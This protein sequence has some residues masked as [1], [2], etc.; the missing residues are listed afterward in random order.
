MTNLFASAAFALLRCLATASVAAPLVLGSAALLGT[1][2]P[3]P[4][5]FALGPH[6]AW[7]AIDAGS[8]A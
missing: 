6:S 3:T 5:A 8:A 2:S 4:A 7:P 1:L